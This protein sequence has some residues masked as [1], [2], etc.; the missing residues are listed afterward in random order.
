MAKVLVSSCLLG[1]NVRYNASQ[2]E[3]NSADFDDV[4]KSHSIISFCPEVAA[5]L[6][7]PRAPAEI[8]QGSGVDVLAGSA[9]IMCQD[10]TDVTEAFI[11]GAELALQ[12]C[13][14]QGV[15]HAILTESSPSCGS[16]NI[17][18]GKFEGVKIP[19]QGVT[20]ALLEKH[21]IKVTNQYELAELTSHS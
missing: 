9:K 21:G 7:I 16:S 17:Y 20:C 3:V 6:V 2:I 13:I 12:V 4:V 18:N 19:G 15:T 5:G 10:Q 14:K 1:C 8:C 11:L